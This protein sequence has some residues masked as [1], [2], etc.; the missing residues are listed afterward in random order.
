MML[1]LFVHFQPFRLLAVEKMQEMHNPV[2]GT[3]PKCD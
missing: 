3:T 2:I 1:V